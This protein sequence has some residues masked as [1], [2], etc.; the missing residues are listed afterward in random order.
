MMIVIDETLGRY[1]FEN[2]YPK[3][4]HTKKGPLPIQDVLKESS[5]SFLKRSL[6]LEPYSQE[7]HIH[8][9]R[10]KIRDVSEIVY[11]YDPSYTDANVL[12]KL[13]NWLFPEQRLTVYPIHQN[14]ALI[15]M[16]IH[17][18]SQPADSNTSTA[19]QRIERCIHSA[20]EWLLTPV[21]KAFNEKNHLSLNKK[22]T[23]KP[24]KLVIKEKDDEQI[25]QIESIDQELQRVLEQ[26]GRQNVWLV[27]KG[28]DHDLNLDNHDVEQYKLEKENLPIHV[29]FIHLISRPTLNVME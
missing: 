14:R 27:Q 24:F 26:N 25:S 19:Y 3:P 23:Q 6:N 2:V 1:D 16:L 28:I 5:G 8:F 11:L 29:P 18:L 21:P 15:L 9:F 22:P 4:V 17:E 13:Q 7:H 20:K 12:K 10:D